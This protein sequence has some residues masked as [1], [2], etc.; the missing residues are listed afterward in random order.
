MRSSSFLYGLLSVVA[1]I[2]G[3]L[4]AVTPSPT[5]NLTVVESLPHVPHGWQ[6][7]DSVPATQRL[8]FRIAVKQENAHAFEQHVINIST[9]DHAK[10]GQH[11]SRD[12]LKTML[13]PSPNATA[14]I[15]SWLT[16]QGVPAKDIDKKGDWIVFCVSAID[17]ER[18]LDSKFYYYFDSARHV[19]EIR[20]LRYSIPQKLHKYIH[21]IQP[22][23][24]FGH[25]RPQISSIYHHFAVGS[26]RDPVGH[27]Y[28]GSRL[29]TTFCNNTI[30]VQ[31]LK[32]L[33][34]LTGYKAKAAEGMQL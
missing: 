34:G 22:T 23:T 1:I 8:R 14:A 6:Q 7:G 27:R 9:P 32:D 30:T 2:N 17:A 5:T 4:A 12:Q 19:K 31:C 20:T 25:V 18:I 28:N 10:Y 24:R 3:V 16:S 11:M 29:N 13:R 15:L 21:M 33:Y 26:S